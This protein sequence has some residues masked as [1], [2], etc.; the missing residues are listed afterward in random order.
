MK[1]TRGKIIRIAK[2][3]ENLINLNFIYENLITF[4]N[5]SMTNF[6]QC[7]FRKGYSSQHSLLV[8]TE[9]FKESIDKG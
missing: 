9:K 2:F 1:R 8:L 7:G 4:T 5:N 3:F 6:F